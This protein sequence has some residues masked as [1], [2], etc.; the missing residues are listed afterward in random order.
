MVF[1]PRTDQDSQFSKWDKLVGLFNRFDLFKKILILNIL[2]L[3][4]LTDCLKKWR[5]LAM[6]AA[7]LKLGRRFLEH[8]TK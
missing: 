8:F 7:L 4:R 6:L 3:N 5:N 2:I 1:N